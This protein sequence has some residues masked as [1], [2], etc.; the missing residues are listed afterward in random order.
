MKETNAIVGIYQTH[1][2]AV[3]AVKTLKEHNFPMD[4]VTLVGKGEESI[5]HIEGFHTWE[6]V[7]NKGI[8][9][10][11]AVGGLMGVLV[12]LGILTIP[13]LGPVYVVGGLAATLF[14]A[15]EGT[16]IGSA[17]GALFGTL[18]GYG[19]GKEKVEKYE[20][21]IEE[22]KYILII[23]GSIED[24]RNSEKILLETQ[25]AHIFTH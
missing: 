3:E 11:G 2:L 16:A 1:E 18:M 6:E 12:G 25:H 19:V 4:K 21:Y 23:H 13:V 10:G 20:N 22:G 5:E 8:K 9:V 15:L 7:T 17:G 14:T 24:V